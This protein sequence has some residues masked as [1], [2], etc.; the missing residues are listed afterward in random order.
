MVVRVS[1]KTTEDSAVSDARH[2][3]LGHSKVVDHAQH[4]LIVC[5]VQYMS[6][7]VVPFVREERI[8]Q[9]QLEGSS[10]LQEALAIF[11][12]LLLPIAMAAHHS[13]V[14]SGVGAHLAI[15][16]PHKHSQVPGR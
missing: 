14:G 12:R 16:V 7:C 6:G 13:T 8:G 9:A 3:A 11:R 10:Q 2:Q 1:I 4:H 15:E 5:P